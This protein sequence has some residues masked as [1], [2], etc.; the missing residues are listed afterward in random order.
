M[1]Y[2]VT[3]SR[4]GTLN[5]LA[6][7]GPL[8]AGDACEAL[9]AAINSCL[10]VQQQ[11]LILDLEQ[12]SLLDGRALEIMLDCHTTLS[13]NGGSLNYINPNALVSD[14][15]S[16]TGL[17]DA[18][19]LQGAP[20]GELHSFGETL[21]PLAP[22]KLGELLVELGLVKLDQ[23]E[24]AAALQSKSGKRMGRILVDRGSITEIDLIR[25]LSQQLNLPYIN[26]RAGL[27]ESAACAL[28][29]LARP[30][31]ALKCCRCSRCMTP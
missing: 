4:I 27:Y 16:A 21:P 9:Q 8:V 14:I 17:G 5:Y 15:L 3:H 6:P 22:M 7:V 25:T 31:A 11:Q 24:A 10:A 28:L 2:T 20:V 29:P 13:Y 19:V 23:V 26:L 30:H 18:T 12:V 1:A